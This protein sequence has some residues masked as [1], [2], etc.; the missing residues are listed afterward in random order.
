[1][2]GLQYG[3]RIASSQTLVAVSIAQCFELLG[4]K[5]ARTGMPRG[6][7]LAAI[8]GFD[9]PDFLGIILSPLLTASDYFVTVKLIVLTSRSAYAIFVLF[10]PSLLVLGYLFLVF[11]VVLSA[12]LDPMGQV[13]PG[14]LVLGVVLQTFTPVLSYP[15]TDTQLAL[16]QVAVSHSRMLVIF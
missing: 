7:P 8:V 1:M 14:F 5:T 9:L 11:L 6:P 15:R 13:C 10:C 2:V 4:G 3:F 16:I 12:C